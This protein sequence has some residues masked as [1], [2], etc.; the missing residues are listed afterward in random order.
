MYRVPE[1]WPALLPPGVVSMPPGFMDV[2]GQWPRKLEV[3]DARLPPPLGY[4]LS[5]EPRRGL[6]VA[7]VTTLASSYGLAA[8]I[9]GGVLA[10]DSDTNELGA[11]LFVP[12][13]GPV[14]FAAANEPITTPSGQL[15]FAFGA[16]GSAIEGTGF[17][18]LLAGFVFPRPVYLR[19]DVD[20]P[21]S[22]TVSIS[23]SPAG[24]TL[25]ATW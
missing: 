7:G 6:W 10:S 8:L 11:L 14:L 5:T 3:D 17:G 19:N 15:G 13:M 23:P 20:G 2:P 16:I 1:A 24:A 9:G 25:H 4:R 12:L 21:P 18:L 22:P